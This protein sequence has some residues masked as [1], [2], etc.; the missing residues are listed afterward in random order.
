MIGRHVTPLACLDPCER[1][2]CNGRPCCR[3]MPGWF[4]G[5]E[6]DWTCRQ[7]SPACSATSSDCLLFVP[8]SKI[9]FRRKKNRFPPISSKNFDFFYLALGSRI[10]FR[11]FLGVENR[12]PA[13]KKKPII[14]QFLGQKIIFFRFW[15]ESSIS[16]TKKSFFLKISFFFDFRLKKK[17]STF[18]GKKIDSCF[19][20]FQK[21]RFFLFRGQ[22]HFFS[23]FGVI[24]QFPL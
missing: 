11:F 1:Q 15:G 20:I 3:R 4:Q 10:F 18:R 2:E 19:P 16:D 5:N 22:N 17:K 12:F 23:N 24:N 14:I 13:Q 6:Q 7:A 8:W 21:I 9:S